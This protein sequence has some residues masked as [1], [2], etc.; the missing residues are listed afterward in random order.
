[1]R[2]IRV[3]VFNHDPN[4]WTPPSDPIKLSIDA[5]DVPVEYPGEETD[6]GVLQEVKE[7]YEM[8]EAISEPFKTSLILADLLRKIIEQRLIEPEEDENDA[9]A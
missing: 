2:W 7:Q 4:R 9:E 5:V 1:M 6:L 3:P 8:L